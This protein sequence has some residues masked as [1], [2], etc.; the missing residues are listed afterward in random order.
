M[1]RTDGD[2]WDVASSV[3]ATAT[4]VAAARAAASRPPNPVINAYQPSLRGWADAFVA[5]VNPV[6]SSLLY[7]TYLGGGDID[8]GNGIAVDNSGN[9][10]VVGIT[11]SDLF[12]TTSGAFQTTFGGL[13]IC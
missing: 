10:Y 8:I 5:K 4:M 6:G 3:G 7:S 1:T 13:S 11:G 12:P 2:R 9:A